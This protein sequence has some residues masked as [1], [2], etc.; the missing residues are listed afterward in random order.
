MRKNLFSIVWI[1]ASALLPASFVASPLQGEDLA[2]RDVTGALL[3][4]TIQAGPQAAEK[5]GE[6]KI[7]PGTEIKLSAIVRNSGDVPSAPGTISIRFAYPKPLDKDPSSIIFQTE[8]LPLPSIAS[9]EAVTIRFHKSHQW[10]SLFDYIRKDWAMRQYEA[11]VVIKGKE[12]L[13]GTRPIS[14]SAYYYP[15]QSEKKRVRVSSL[16]FVPE[17]AQSMR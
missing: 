6:E 1:A 3:S 12:Y 13:A 9:G 7:L 14:F 11:A 5:P 2:K 15:G 8:E 17:K 10:P 4:A 16:D